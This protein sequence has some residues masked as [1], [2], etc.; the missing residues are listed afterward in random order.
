MIDAI[1]LVVLVATF[2]LCA[3]FAQALERMWIHDGHPGRFCR[4]S[5]DRISLGLGFQ[6]REI[7]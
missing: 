1:Y 7:L 3:L 2:G 4:C 6:A 5:V